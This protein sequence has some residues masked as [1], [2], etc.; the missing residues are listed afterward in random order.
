MTAYPIPPARRW[1]SLA[2]RIAL[3][4]AMV[5]LLLLVNSHYL[6]HAELYESGDAGANSLSVLRAERGQE[7]YGAYSRWMFHHPGPALFYTEA[8][9]EA[10][11]YRWRHLTPT[12]YNAQML[13]VIVL[14]VS[15]FAA[16]V[17][18]AARWVRGGVFLALA[19]AFAALH[20]TAVDGRLLVVSTWPPHVAPLIFF[21]LIVAAASVGAGQGEDLPML[22]LAGCFLLHLHVAQPLFVGP[23]CLLGYGGLWWSCWRRR[24]AAATPAVSLSKAN[25][26]PA[27]AAPGLAASS[28]PWRTYRRTH[29]LAALIAGCFALPILVD[30]CFSN[31]NFQQIRFHLKTHRGQGYPFL[32]SL[33]YFLRFAVYHPSLHGA[34]PTLNEATT[35]QSLWKF[36]L[37]HVQMAILWVGALLSPLLPLAARVWRGKERPSP[38]GEGPAPTEYAS[39]TGRWRF[40]GWLWAAWALS[41]GL[42]LFWGT[43]QDGELFYFNAWFN[44]SIW[45]VLALLAAGSMAD[46]VDVLTHRSDRRLPWRFAVVGACAVLAGFTLT[47]HPERFRANDGDG[48]DARQQQRSVA[49]RLA[50][51]PAGTPRAK[52]LVFPHDGWESATGLAV[53]LARNG[54]PSAVL[55]DW[56][57]MFGPDH[58]LVDW[59][60]MISKP[61]DT[62]PTFEIWHVVPKALAP[63]EEGRFP[64]VSDHALAPGGLPIN[65][66][67]RAAIAWDGE[68]VNAAGYALNWEEGKTRSTARFSAVQ[69]RPAPV[70]P[71]AS[72]KITFDFTVFPFA[73]LHR[74]QRLEIR[75][76]G[77]DL[78]TLTF[79]PEDSDPQSVVVPAATWNRYH[80]V[81]MTLR[82]LDA[83]APFTIGEG[84]ER[85]PFAVNAHRITFALAGAVETPSSAPERNV[86]KAEPVAVP[87]A[88]SPEAP[89]AATPGAASTKTLLPGEPTPAPEATPTEATPQA[90]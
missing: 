51:E 18:Q 75:Y 1:Q 50:T 49:D 64:L 62:N 29:R 17:S 23:M 11:F 25:E 13:A 36:V 68:G 31:G 46:A 87:G 34:G 3:A 63:G 71:E 56:E 28:L 60:T 26:A 40:L 9:G 65:P 54:R 8:L 39:P 44:Y 78:G 70:P 30:L 42:T 88:P 90:F 41:V 14:L 66:A 7:L 5:Y 53:L 37:E 22:V 69:F 79:S 76:N 83:V 80:A 16:G 72:V 4:A 32:T 19:L 47:R 73:K 12:P 77:N 89:P 74:P 21:G 57:F 38:T 58:R 55:P 24:G 2:L 81:L 6:F 82:F 45:Y 20:F 52:L 86:G 67:V 15:L 27:P 59:Q 10:A 35:S 33:A 48:D 61:A 84:E 43:I 85:R